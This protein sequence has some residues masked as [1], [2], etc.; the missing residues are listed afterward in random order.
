MRLDSSNIAAASKGRIIYKGDDREVTNIRLDSREAGEGDLFVPI[1]GE[2]TDAHRFLPDVAAKS[3]SCIF[4]SRHHDPEELKKDAPFFDA[5]EKSRAEGTAPSVIFTEDTVAALQ[6]L[7]AW[8][9][10]NRVH[11]PVIGVTGSVGKTTTREMTACALSGGKR[12]YATKGNLNSQVG[13]PMTVT[14]IEDEDIAVLELGIS[15]PGEMDRIA[16]ITAPDAAIITNIGISHIEYLGSRENIMKEKL[17][18][19]AGSGKPVR[20]F[21]NGDNDLLSGLTRERLE[22]LSIP[23]SAVS[24]MIFCGT[25]EN[26]DV[27]AEDIDEKDGYASFTASFYRRDSDGR[28][29]DRPYLTQRVSLTIPGSH[30]MIDALLALAVSVSF[31]VDPEKAAEKLAAFSSLKGRGEIFEKEGITVI[32]DCYNAAPDSMKAALSVLLS[33]ACE[34]RRIAVLADM[35]ELGAGSKELHREIGRYLTESAG[36]PDMLLLFGPESRYIEDGISDRGGMEVRHF[37]EMEGL[38]DFLRTEL[39]PGDLILFKGSNSMGLSKAI[40]SIFGK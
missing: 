6:E 40:S 14:G 23:A 19:A 37:D 13:V 26:C 18:I 17:R 34:G 25:S 36:K 4:T 29:E 24:E 21:L 7:G 15:K 5:L 20:L 31:G 3:V 30:M 16:H 33:K 35:L 32:D 9:R 27:R 8:Y 2:K 28:L 38:M 39:S 11:M 10:R 12:V 22:E 1:I